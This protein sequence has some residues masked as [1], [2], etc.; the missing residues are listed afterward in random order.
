MMRK[1]S[2]AWH[3]WRGAGGRFA[4]FVAPAAVVALAAAGTVPPHTPSLP[5]GGIATVAG[6]VGGPATATRVAV[7]PE[8]HPFYAGGFLYFPDGGLVRKMNARTGWLTTPAGTGSTGPLRD[9]GLATRTAL[10]FA[11]GVAFDHAG[12]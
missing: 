5:A 6:G 4:A 8:G 10:D 12:N 2:R 7:V 3:P 9:G 1:A 11:A